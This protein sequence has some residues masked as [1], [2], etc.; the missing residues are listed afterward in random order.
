MPKSTISEEQQSSAPKSGKPTVEQPTPPHWPH[1]ATQHAWP[2]EDSIPGRPLLHKESISMETMVGV[3]V[4]TSPLIPMG[5]GVESTVCIGA[6]TVVGVGVDT[7]TLAPTGIGG[8]ID[9][10]HRGGNG[11]RCWG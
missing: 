9:G 4:D 2:L 8:R 10:L 6:E 7:S 11:G 3:A 5:M 1:T